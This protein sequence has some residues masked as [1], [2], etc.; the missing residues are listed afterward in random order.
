MGSTNR[1]DL[2][3]GF[4]ATGGVEML[5]TSGG[6]LFASEFTIYNWRGFSIRC[7]SDTEPSTTLVTDNDG[8]NYSWIQIGSQYWLQQSLKTT[9]YNNGDAIATGLDDAAWSATTDGAWSYP[10]GDMNLPI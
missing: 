4:L 1:V 2:G 9:T 6:E 10:N 3:G 8:N 5:V 7:V